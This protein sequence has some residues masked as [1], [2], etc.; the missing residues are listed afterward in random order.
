LTDERMDRL[1]GGLLRAGV[2]ISA[3]VTL[4]GGFWR[5][6]QTGTAL[7]DYRT[8]H[9]EPADLRGVTGVLHGIAQGHSAALIQFGL[10]LLIATPV[11]RV[12][13]CVIAFAAEGDRTYVAITLLVLAVLL[14]SLS[15]LTL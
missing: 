6:A 8:F 14:A 12:V 4:A 1:I 9:G 15:G 2:I 11:A 3:A 10:L 5:L 7:A 13:L